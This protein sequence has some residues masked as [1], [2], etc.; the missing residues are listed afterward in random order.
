M[1]MRAE[2]FRDVCSKIELKRDKIAKYLGVEM[3]AMDDMASGK[4]KV[5]P[6]IAAKLYDLRDDPSMLSSEPI[7]EENAEPLSAEQVKEG[8]KF[9]GYTQERLGHR[10]GLPTAY[11]CNWELGYNTPRPYFVNKFAAML[12]R[13]GFNKDEIN[14]N[15]KPLVQDF[16]RARTR[17]QLVPL[18]NTAAALKEPNENSILSRMHIFASTDINNGR[19]SYFENSFELSLPPEFVMELGAD[20]GDKLELLKVRGDNLAPLKDGEIIVFER[21]NAAKIGDFVL[22]C[23]GENLALKR[24]E[25]GDKIL[26]VILARISLQKM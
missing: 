26:G 19:G 5:R 17:T 9:L 7:D 11:I 22:I 24:F 10:L 23:K 3:Q 2:I 18:D 20:V 25:I 14:K 12:K 13:A 4:L 8:R 1:K 21:T 6:E 16:P 15:E